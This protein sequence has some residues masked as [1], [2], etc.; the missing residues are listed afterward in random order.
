MQN[1]LTTG[2]LNISS[3]LVLWSIFACLLKSSAKWTI[4]KCL[5]FQLLAVDIRHERNV[6]LQCIRYIVHDLKLIDGTKQDRLSNVDSM[7]VPESD[8]VAKADQESNIDSL[9]GRVAIRGDNNLIMPDQNS[10]TVSVIGQGCDGDDAT[11]PEQTF[12]IDSVARQESKIVAELDPI[13]NAYS[14]VKQQKVDY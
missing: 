12:N 8:D 2:R 9:V 1:I 10:D 6:I 5:L 13:F 14:M 3:I 11:V 7:V 4:I